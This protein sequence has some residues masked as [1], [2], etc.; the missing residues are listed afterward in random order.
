V[1]LTRSARKHGIAPED[2]EGVLAAPLRVVRQG[3]TELHIGVTP[4]RDLLEVVIAPGDPVVV[5]HAMRLR[6][7]NYRWLAEPGRE[8]AAGEQRA[9]QRAGPDRGGG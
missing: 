9:A 1:R 8:P 7:Y 6:P 5:L 3:D 4:R 2:I